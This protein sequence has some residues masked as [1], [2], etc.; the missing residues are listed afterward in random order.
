M[1]GGLKQR[2]LQ[3]ELIKIVLYVQANEIITNYEVQKLFEVSKATASR[4]LKELEH[5]FIEK[6]GTTGVG[7]VYVLKGLIKGS[8]KR[9]EE[10]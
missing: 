1:E 8:L 3:D 10:I 5:N 6:M 4:Y 7:T 2:G 9:V